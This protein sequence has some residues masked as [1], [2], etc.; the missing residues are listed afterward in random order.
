M[1]TSIKQIKIQ[2]PSVQPIFL[3]VTSGKDIE[4]R[5]N[6]CD[7]IPPRPHPVGVVLGILP[8]FVYIHHYGDVPYIELLFLKDWAPK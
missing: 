1:A 8:S 7:S 4:K 6:V 5:S 2:I 3:S